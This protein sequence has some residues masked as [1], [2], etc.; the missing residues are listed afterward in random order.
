MGSL[1]VW[2]RFRWSAGVS[3]GAILAS[4]SAALASAD[5]PSP[6]R[7]SPAA[8]AGFLLLLVGLAYLWSRLR[9]RAERSGRRRLEAEVEAK[10]VELLTTVSRLHQAQR[11]A[12]EKNRL[13]AEA[14]ARLERLSLVDELTGVANRRSLF[15]RLDEEL[16]RSLRHGA[17]LSFVLFDLDLFKAVNDTLGHEEGDRCL[18]RLGEFLCGAMRRR[19]DLVARYGGEEFA[20]VLPD[21]PLDGGLRVAEELRAGIEALALGSD[22]TGSPPPA[23]VTASFAVAATDPACPETAVEL[24]RRADAALYRAKQDGRNRVVA[25]APPAISSAE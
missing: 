4:G 19:A 20:L 9:T 12:E 7:L 10:T 11:E 24:V 16:S 6:S 18:E 15:R 1:A 3:L 25:A 23:R 13:L 17:P 8:A 2:R 5:G 14:N 21:T 22:D